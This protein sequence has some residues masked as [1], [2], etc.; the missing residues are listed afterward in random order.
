MNDARNGRPAGKEAAEPTPAT[1]PAKKTKPARAAT[2]GTAQ[3]GRSLRAIVMKWGDVGAL[4]RAPVSALGQ[5][6]ALEETHGPRALRL[7]LALASGIVLLAIVWSAFI[8]LDEVAVGPGEVV[9]ERPIATV[10]HLEGGIVSAIYVKDGDLVEKNQ[11]LLLLRGESADAEL[12]QLRAREAALAVRAQRL[13]AFVTGETLSPASIEALGRHGELAKEE[14]VVLSLQEKTRELQRS[15]IQRQIEQKHSQLGVLREQEASIKKQLATVGE[16]LGLR[17][18]GE[19]KGVVSRALYLQTRREH[20]RVLG[21]AGENAAQI[22]RADQELAEARVRLAEHD[23]RASSEAM[24]E[25]GKVLGELAQVRES[26]IKLE[27]RVRRLEIRTP[28]RG[29]VKGLRITAA[30]AVITTDGKP[31][32]EI[33]PVDSRLMV[34]AR[35]STRDIGHVRIGQP[36]RVRID[37]YDFARYGAIPGKVEMLSA[38]TYLDKEGRPYYRATISLDRAYVGLPHNQ[39]EVSPGMTVSVDVIT[40]SKSLLAYLIKPVYQ[41]LA[42]GLRER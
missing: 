27:D 3:F 7:C 29:H 10:Q 42:F 38:A 20:E 40:G 21:E 33:V 18:E 13:R 5:A 12:Q 30:D 39:L 4:E 1:A 9:T 25:R 26:L 24:N 23:A 17:E 15:M 11:V 16:S 2:R 36:V 14:L 41:S 19:K 35:I 6:A 22:G 32:M 31:L 37:T 8:R 28:V 34:E